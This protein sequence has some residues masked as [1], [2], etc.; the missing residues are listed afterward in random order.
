MQMKE[1]IN[2]IKKYYIKMRNDL[3]RIQRREQIVGRHYLKERM[4]EHFSE[5]VKNIRFSVN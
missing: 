2:E 5:L 1:I 3:I 4:A